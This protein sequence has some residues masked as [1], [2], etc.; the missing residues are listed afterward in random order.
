VRKKNEQRKRKEK[1]E[2]KNL[3]RKKISRCTYMAKL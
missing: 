3:A 1:K 2:L